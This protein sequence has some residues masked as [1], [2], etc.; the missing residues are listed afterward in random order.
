M[1]IT[2]KLWLSEYGYESALRAF[3]ASLRRLQLDYV[4]LYLLH[5]L[6]PSHFD[7]T[8]ASYQAAEKLLAEGRTRAIGVSKNFRPTHLKNLLERTEVVPA[9]NQV[10]LHPFFLQQELR[11]THGRLGIITPKG[12][13]ALT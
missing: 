3:D 10:E 11:E 12:A 7:A 9:V 4:D 2:T 5:W 1:F 8:V 6:V 13:L